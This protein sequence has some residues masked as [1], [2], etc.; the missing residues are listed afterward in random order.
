M[1]Y[2]KK[3]SRSHVVAAIAGILI[4]GASLADW[5]W[6][7]ALADYGWSRSFADFTWGRTLAD[8][9]WGRMMVG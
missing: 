3:I 9:S 4:V 5:G 8:F 6:S 2:R 1:Q 7:R